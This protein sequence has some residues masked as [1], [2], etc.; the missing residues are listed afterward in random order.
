MKLSI[1][2]IILASSITIAIGVGL[3]V[4]TSI[5]ALST[6][7]VGGPLFSQLKLDYDL[8]ADILPPPEYIIEPYLDITLAMQSD[9]AVP[10]LRRRLTTLENG[11]RDRKD[12]WARQSL[13]NEN[14]NLLA[15]TGASA[16]RFWQTA[17]Q[18]LLPALER[19]DRPAAARAYAELS[20]IYAVHRSQIDALV[21]H[22]NA[23]LADHEKLADRKT[24][25][26]SMAVW[27]IS[28][29]VMLLLGAAIAGLF[30]KLLSPLLH[31]TDAT[32][33]LAKGNL[34]TVIPALERSDE[35][36]A[37]AASLGEFRKAA[38]AERDRAERES[39]RM[40]AE[41]AA[42]R[43]R[44]QAEQ[45]RMEADQARAAQVGRMA[46]QIADGF[47]QLANGNLG[48][49]LAEAFPPDF[50]QLRADFN[51]TA[52]KLEAKRAADRSAAEETARTVAALAVGLKQLSSGHLDARLN[53]T[54]GGE[55]ERLRT[56]FNTMAAQL[57][58]TLE[59]LVTTIS[60]INHGAAE[61]N[62]A[63]SDL[64]G[65]TERQAASLE[66]TAAAL[67]EI[68][69]TVRR[70]A[71]SARDASAMVSSARSAADSGGQIVQS[72][73]NAMEQIEKSS[74]EI[75]DIIVVIDEIAFQTNLLALNAGVEAARAGDSGRG[76]AVVAS[77]VRALAQRSSDAARQ[78]KTL[79]HASSEHVSSGVAL[80]GDSGKALRNIVRQ[81]M[82]I[83]SLVEDMALSAQQ[84]SSGLDQVNA[85]IAQMDQLT[86][87]NAAMVEESNAAMN[88]LVRDT[89]ALSRL[90]S[91]FKVRED[92]P[93]TAVRAA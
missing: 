58:E 82:E 19:H 33:K 16:E 69:T 31:I 54:F 92:G 3:A 10:A 53:G 74:R 43:D 50:E 65:R 29:A 78:I 64:S 1:R 93:Q 4:T 32:Q 25:G 9:A 2:N 11:Y 80:V 67:E 87:Q 71:S 27:I 88:S 83:N 55:Y 76:I 42:E 61:I 89:S 35:L 14:R 37:L 30:R 91:F 18:T 21:T 20:K 52:S 49:R 26:F 56:D 90:A 6:L 73:V 70:T 40:H 46:G 24:A 60:G 63:T 39:T 13:K 8:L 45:Q 36:G 38:I 72:T 84:Q 23:S 68:T 34:E 79:I 7:R 75:A 86:Q 59:A 48:V 5:V 22:E 66:E 15:Q 51:A 17:D 47:S 44:A 81:V 62:Q 41:A 77:E 85:A 28:A 12:Y 57:E